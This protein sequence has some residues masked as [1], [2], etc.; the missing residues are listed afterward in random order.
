[1]NRQFQPLRRITIETINA[2]PAP[3]SPFL[4]AFRSGFDLMVEAN[5][6]VLYR[7]YDQKKGTDRKTEGDFT[8]FR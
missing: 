4:D 2:R 8:G 7:K 6:V 3:Q 5:S 1:M